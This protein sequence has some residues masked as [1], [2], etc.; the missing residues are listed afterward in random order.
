MHQGLDAAMPRS[1]RDALGPRRVKA[2]WKQVARGGPR[3]GQCASRANHKMQPV[4]P[5]KPIKKGA[6]RRR[7]R[8]M[9]R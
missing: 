8:R 5:P 7:T 9:R 6:R 3:T 2:R 1:F 4:C